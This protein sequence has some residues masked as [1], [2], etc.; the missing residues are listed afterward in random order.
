MTTRR[1]QRQAHVRPRP[2]SGSRPAPVKV[3]PRSPGPTRI[4]SH[5]TVQ[6]PGGLPVY[7]R[8]ALVFG[9]VML[10]ALVLYVGVG[11][12][13]MV[14][15]GVSSTLGGFVSDVTS[16][17]SPKATI[18]VVAD[19]PTLA[20]PAEPYTS[21]GTIDLV[22]TVPPAL[23]GST[24]QRIKVYLT[25][26]DQPPTAI[27][28]VEIAD[29][30]R[31]VIP[32]ELTKG[33]NDFS[34]A[35]VGPGGE[36]DPSAVVRYVFDASPPKITITSPKNNGVVNGKA[37]TIKGKTQ[38][39]TT[40]LARNDANGSSVAGTAGADG[41]FQLSL[42]LA[43][44]SNKITITGTDPAGNE[45]EATVTVRRGSGKLTAS[46]SASD[47]RIKRSQLPESI[48]LSATVT[49]PDG[50]ALADADITFTLSI[51]GIPTVTVDGHTNKNGKASF[52]TTIPKGADPGQGSATVLVTSDEF[53]SAQDFTVITITK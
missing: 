1:D 14:A 31:T 5:R 30:P 18:P 35:I 3:K 28:E 12:V 39:R 53:G 17:P 10:G 34:V 47:Y 27:T 36:S 7:W 41:T 9:V 32:V 4:A 38:A 8:I 44:G 33:I 52:K 2:P 51:P 42:A 29:G 49:D 37:A 46:L 24:D 6:R 25:L 48:T 21:V 26:P 43:P 11:G 22:V 15:R 45:A 16:T 50:K 20:Q 40:L 13:G 23:Q 19:S